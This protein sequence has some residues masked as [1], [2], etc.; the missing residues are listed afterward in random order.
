MADNCK[1]N[2]LCV[3][4]S[5]IYASKNMPEIAVTYLDKNVNNYGLWSSDLGNDQLSIVCVFSS[6]IQPV[7]NMDIETLNYLL[8]FESCFSLSIVK[9]QKCL[10]NSSNHM[11]SINQIFF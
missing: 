3:N 6:V 1:K 4:H 11:Q 5:Y 9:K 10:T 8:E 7:I 2:H